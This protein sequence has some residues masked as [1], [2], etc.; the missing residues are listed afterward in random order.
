[1]QGEPVPP[2]T[3]PESWIVEELTNAVQWPEVTAPDTETPPPDDADPP[4]ATATPAIPAIS[5]R[6]AA[7]YRMR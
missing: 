7:A 1:M 2:Q 3:P 6:S 4:C 5:R